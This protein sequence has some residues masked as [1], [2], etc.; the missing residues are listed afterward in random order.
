MHLILRPTGRFRSRLWIEEEEFDVVALRTLTAHDLLPEGLLPVNIE[1]LVE[2]L[3]PCAYTFSDLGRGI[4]GRVTFGPEGPSA[5]EIHDQ[6]D[7]FDNP[8]INRRCRSTLAHECGHGILHSCL[9]AELWRLGPARESGIVLTD[10]TRN[11]DESVAPDPERWFEYQANRMMASLLLPM[12]HVIGCIG[13]QYLE[14]DRYRRLSRIDRLR[15]AGDLRDAFD[16]NLSLA[17]YRLDDIFGK[18]LPRL[19]SI[20]ASGQTPSY[21]GLRLCWPDELFGERA[22]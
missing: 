11:L 20:N 12:G 8:L 3:F 21:E 9:F 1:L 14:R 22:A 7:S 15:L 19:V 6:L 13:R 4:M 2:R 5:I 10:K 17:L 16:V 18:V